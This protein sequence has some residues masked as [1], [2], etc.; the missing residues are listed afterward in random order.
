MSRLLCIE[1][2]LTNVEI[3]ELDCDSKKSH[4]RVD[5]V[6]VLPTPKGT[7]T[8]KGLYE[9]ETLAYSIR[10]VLDE[11]HIKTKDA[12]F[13]INTELIHS[14][15][16][17][18]PYQNTSTK[19][20]EV[21]KAKAEE[22][23][24]FPLELDNNVLSYVELSKTAL[25]EEIEK[26]EVV[27]ESDNNETDNDK[28]NKK[29]KGTK[30]KKKNSNVGMIQNLMGF[31][32]PSEFVKSYL[33]L[34]RLAKLNVKS[35]EYCGNSTYNFI[36]NMQEYKQGSYMIV[37]ITD[38]DCILTTIED[39]LMVEQRST[40]YSYS[41]FANPLIERSKL[42]NNV[43][44]IDDTFRYM[45]EVNFFGLT[46]SDLDKMSNLNMLDKEDY[47]KVKEE[48]EDTFLSLFGRISSFLN[49]YRISNKKNIDKIIFVNERESFP[50]IIESIS[51]NTGVPTEKFVVTNRNCSV[52]TGKNTVVIYEDN[53]NITELD[54]SQ[55]DLLTVINCLGA[56]INPVNFNILDSEFQRRKELTNRVVMG[57]I[58]GSLTVCV[59]YGLYNLYAFSSATTKNQK[60]QLDIENATQAKE[61]FNKY[62]VSVDNLDSINA[63]EDSNYTNLNEMT[64][65]LGEIEKV[66]PTGLLTIES[67]TGNNESITLAI[68]ALDK[69][70]IAYFI[71]GLE[72]LSWFSPYDEEGNPTGARIDFSSVVDTY[73]T[74]ATIERETSTSLTCYFATPLEEVEA[75]LESEM[76]TESDGTTD[77][78]VIEE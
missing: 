40:E 39:G 10:N 59:F 17:D 29:E 18:I 67:V 27:E 60:L 14:R 8:Q 64:D 58:L 24:I 16:V 38:F 50:D 65:I 12:I 78:E 61:I 26:E 11:Q 48:V 37:Q 45:N 35:I 51:V 36:K 28:E 13:T 74:D 2:G 44:G 63:F 47:W 70:A 25:Q 68:R 42:F 23:K 41:T 46:E 43:T 72:G 33:E 19:V 9:V 53:K 49:Q 22:D 15:R 76:T 62:A 73:T 34:G 75:P 20:L 71:E 4:L 7:V 54:F 32:V 21:L 1:C 66:I 52:N 30:K 5:K 6:I 56:Y 55:F 57:I 77:S 69:D 31:I 3:C